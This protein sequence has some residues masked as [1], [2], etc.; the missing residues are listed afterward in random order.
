V[1]TSLPVVIEIKNAGD[2]NNAIDDWEASLYDMTWR[3]TQGLAREL[4]ITLVNNSAQFSGDFA[5]N[6]NY[7]VGTPNYSF[8]ENVFNGRYLKTAIGPY[9]RP[10]GIT[11]KLIMGHQAALQVAL[12]KVKSSG[13]ALGQTIYLT[14]AAHHDEPYAEMIESGT[15]KFRS[16]NIGHP[17]ARSLALVST[18]Y[19]VITGN[20]LTTLARKFN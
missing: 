20:Q 9:G 19:S 6:W 7:S 3:A 10:Q 2:F 4:L 12:A 17:V 13:F 5:A 16:G 18:K 1:G 11:S 14:N 8:K 15:V